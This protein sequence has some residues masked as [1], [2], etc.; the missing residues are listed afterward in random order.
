LSSTI[1]LR[2]FAKKRNK[3]TRNGFNAFAWNDGF[4]IPE[5]TEEQGI[6]VAPVVTMQMPPEPDEKSFYD[7]LL[8]ALQAPVKQG[9]TVVHF[10]DR[11]ATCSE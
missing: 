10:A 4:L 7:E 1:W 8:G 3:A 5:P 2:S 11:R 9:H 6:T